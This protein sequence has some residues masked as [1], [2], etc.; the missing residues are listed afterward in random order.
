M[1][2]ADSLLTPWADFYVIVGT[3]GATLT[4]LM[5]VVVTLTS[6]ARAPGDTHTVDAF[7]TPNVVHFGAP[8]LVAGTLTAP[9][10][11]L[12]HAGVALGVYGLA[13]AG[14]CML[15]L[16]RARRQ[17]KYRPV[18]EDWLFHVVFPTVVYAALAAAGFLL[19]R[20][21]APALFVAGAAAV[22][23]LGVGIHN[24]WDTMT[25]V[26]TQNGGRPDGQGDDETSSGEASPKAT[27]P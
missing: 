16:R 13:G 17:T 3:A 20:A 22:A 14:Y 24:A 19:R 25:Y 5:F 27:S 18:L 11:D 8:L 1:P 4:G 21:P 6:R 26:A 9:W 10:H 7:A 15:V 2:A 23:L 12:A